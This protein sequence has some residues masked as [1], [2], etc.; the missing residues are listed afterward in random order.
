[1]RGLVKSGLLDK[2]QRRS[3]EVET[4]DLIQGEVISETLEESQLSQT[5]RSGYYFLHVLMATVVRDGSLRPSSHRTNALL[6]G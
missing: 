6:P 3:L 5:M 4:T 1:M 2:R